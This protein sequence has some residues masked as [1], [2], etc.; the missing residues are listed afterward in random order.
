MP[1][2]TDAP[3][4]R[5]HSSEPWTLDRWFEFEHA[6]GS[7]CCRT[8]PGHA[9]KLAPD[10]DGY[11]LACEIGKE[12]HRQQQ[13]HQLEQI[14]E[15]EAVTADLPALNSPALIKLAHSFADTWHGQHSYSP[16]R[17]WYHRRPGK[18]WRPDP[19]SIAL[20]KRV[21]TEIAAQAKQIGSVNSI[22]TR[23]VA[24]E[25]EPLLAYQGDWDATPDLAGL[26]D[27]R[28]IDLATGETRDAQ[29]SDRITRRLGAVP[30]DAIP[31]RW[32]QVIAHVCRDDAEAEWLHRWIGYCLTGRTTEHKFAFFAGPGGGGKSVL[33]ETIRKVAGSYSQG[34]PEDVFV[35]GATRHREWLARLAG[36]RV[37]VVPDL[38][39]GSWRN[40]GLLK[41]LVAGDVQSANFMRRGTFDFTPQLKLI[42][43]GNSKPRLTRADSG[44]ER[45]LVLIP[46]A[47]VKQPDNTLSTA[48][49]NELGAITAWAIAGAVAYLRSGLPPVPDRWARA[50]ANYHRDEDDIAKWFAASCELDGE[51]FSPAKQ[52]VASYSDYT[53]KKIARATPIYEWLAAKELDNVKR[54][55]MRINGSKHPT[56]G[57]QGVRLCALC[58]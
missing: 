42:V 39:G 8:E 20:R 17:G 33:I 48:L 22:R 49:D 16:N 28:V 44:L 18:L 29:P 53:G 21:S 38:P 31:T 15:E 13:Q 51:A 27:D 35:D 56:D 30:I 34:I 10:A 32:L 14:P 6:A 43:A 11:Y 57:V 3:E 41:S 58:A 54:A 47:R 45:R 9:F 5:N 26:P 40:V 36:A 2:L 23:T 7:C 25:I 19:E 12:Q 24:Q 50:A 4:R 46:V 55:R 1:T 37:A 52:L